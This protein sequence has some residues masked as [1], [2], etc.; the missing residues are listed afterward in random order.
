MTEVY[1]GPAVVRPPE[2]RSTPVQARRRIFQR[3]W[4][5]VID[6]RK[7]LVILLIFGCVHVAWARQ[8]PFPHPG[9]GRSSPRRFTGI[10]RLF[11]R[12]RRTVTRARR[13]VGHR[14]RRR[15]R[16]HRR[17]R[18]T[19]TSPS[20]APVDARHGLPHRV[21]DQELHRDRDPEAARRRQAVARRSGRTLRAGAEGARY[22]TTRLAADHDPPPA[23]AR[24]GFPEDNPWGDQQLADTDERAVAMLRGGHSVLE[25]ARRRLRVLELRLRDPRPHRRATS[26]GQP[27]RRL[28]RD[29]TSCGRSA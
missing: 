29:D 25:R 10:D 17:H 26:R 3:S 4:S 5:Q 18:A 14:H 28:R 20:K 23:V 15:A 13:G 7:C 12:V 1:D 19:A 27:Y 16:A 9:A 11:D 24:G 6:M 8:A 22:P 21:D 2:L